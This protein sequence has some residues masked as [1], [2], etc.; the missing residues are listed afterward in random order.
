MRMSS[1]L[2][3]A[4]TTLMPGG[5]NSPVRSFIY[6]EHEPV[7]VR[8]ARGAIIRTA[9]DEELVDFVM[10]WGAIILGHADQRTVAKIK[11]AAEHGS[12]YGLCHER[13]LEFTRILKKIFPDFLFRIVN[14]GTEATMTAVRLARAWT[15]RKLVIR[16]AGC[17]H[18]HSD[19]FLTSAGSGM[20]TMSLPASAGVPQ[21][22]TSCTIT[23]DFNAEESVIREIFKKHDISSVILEPVAANM[24]VV[25]PK[26]SF[27]RT[28]FEECERHS[29]VVIFDEVIT[30]FR[31]GWGGVSSQQV[32]RPMIFDSEGFREFEIKV[33]RPH[34]ITL[35]KIVGGGFPVGVVC[36]QEKIMNLLAPA[37]P[38]YQ[39]GTFSANPI[40]LT[41]GI[42]T[43]MTISEEED[44][45]YRKLR[46]TTKDVVEVLIDWS[47]KRGVPISVT[48][49]TGMLSVFFTER[50]P[51]NLEEVKKSDIGMFRRF[52]RTLLKNGILIPPSPFEAWFISSSHTEREIQKLSDALSRF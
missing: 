29:A 10:S 48:A 33:Q 15:G 50:A 41:A 32:I 3:R 43:L 37:G 35:G 42:Q 9:D 8:S 23:L 12:S 22:F 39:A 6:V 49:E 45:F 20:A 17:F 2:F 30:G 52:F 27:V 11:E 18:G 5:V 13:E 25:F 40:S 28:L 21:E 24:G 26:E 38:V 19:Q 1:E 36:G 51:K 31:I 16:F 46:K 47:L 7:Y 4:A 14:T 44:T 34:I